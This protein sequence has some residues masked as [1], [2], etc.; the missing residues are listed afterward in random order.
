MTDDMLRGVV[1]LMTVF[2]TFL[3]FAQ[4][5]IVARLEQIIRLLENNQKGRP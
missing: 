1:L 4:A 2:F 3:L 5:V